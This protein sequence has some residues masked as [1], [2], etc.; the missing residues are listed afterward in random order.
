MKHYNQ[1]TGFWSET[2]ERE[3][4]GKLRSYWERITYIVFDFT[5][6]FLFSFFSKDHPK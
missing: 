4:P 5:F 2:A 3:V 6:S 1:E